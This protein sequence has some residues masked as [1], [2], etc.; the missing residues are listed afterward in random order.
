M[1]IKATV[2]HCI[3]LLSGGTQKIYSNKCCQ[4]CRETVALMHPCGTE[5]G[6]A[7][8]RDGIALP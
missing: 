3:T 8:L 7:T 2:Q 5:K 4:G 6:V 1:K